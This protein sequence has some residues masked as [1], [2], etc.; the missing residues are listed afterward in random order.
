MTLNRRTILVSIAALLVIAVGATVWLSRRRAPTSR[1]IRAG[2][3]A[4]TA[5]SASSSIPGGPRPELV[6]QTGHLDR[7]A[8]VAF[9]P[10][11]RLLASS[12]DDGTVKLWDVESRRQLRSFGAPDTVPPDVG[13]STDGQWVTATGILFRAWSVSTGRSRDSDLQPRWKARSANGQWLAGEGDAGILVMKDAPGADTGQWLPRLLAGADLTPHFSPDDR[14]LAVEEMNRLGRKATVADM[15]D[16]AKIRALALNDSAEAAIQIWEVNTWR[17]VL[18]IPG[19][20]PELSAP[21][22]STDGRWLAVIGDG[23]RLVE[24]WDVAQAHQ[25]RTLTAPT[26]LSVVAFSPDSRFV[27]AAAVSKLDFLRILEEHGG[28]GREETSPPDD[29]LVLW[30]LSAE[31][32]PRTVAAGTGINALAFSPDGRKLAVAGSQGVTYWDPQEASGPPVRVDEGE[33]ESVTFSADGRRIA[34]AKNSS[35]KVR[36]LA[37]GAAAVVMSAPMMP[38]GFVTLSPDGR[39]LATANEER[40]S[41]KGADTGTVR[42]WDVAAGREAH[43]LFPDPTA[44]SAMLFSTD[45]RRIMTFGS[46]S[47]VWNTATGR[48]VGTPGD[49]PGQRPP[50]FVVSDDGRRLAYGIDEQFRIFVGDFESGKSPRRFSAGGPVDDLVLSADGRWLAT[51]GCHYTATR[52]PTG[53]AM[54]L[55][56][57]NTLKEIRT[58]N[59]NAFNLAISPDGRH[60]AAAGGAGRPGLQVWDVASGAQVLSVGTHV[61]GSV[62]VVNAISFSPDGRQVAFSDDQHAIQI[63]DVVARKQ[64]IALAGHTNYVG[65]IVFD[66]QGRIIS[67]SHDGTIRL[68]NAAAGELLVTLLF[69]QDPK[70]WLAVTP[71]GLFDGSPEAWNRIL[72]RFYENTFDVAPVDTFFSEFYYPGLLG[73]VFAGRR[74][75]P[76]RDIGQLDRRQPIVRL[77]AA[78]SDAGAI[79][80]RRI[81]VRVDVDEAHADA[82]H[83]AGSG[84]RDIRL[85]RDGSL[86]KAWRGDVLAS[87][88]GRVSLE[89]SVPIVAG[90]NRF[91]AYAFNHDNVKSEDAVL[92]VTGATGL[93]RQGTAYVLAV[94]VNEYANPTFNLKYAVADARRF[95]EVLARQQRLVGRFGDVQVIPLMDHDATKANV[96]AALK[97]LAGPEASPDGTAGLPASIP[98]IKPAE[99]EDLVVLFFAGHGVTDGARF[100]MVPHDLGYAGRRDA[101]DAEAV[102]TIARHSLSDQELERA[103]EDVDAGHLLLVIDACHSGQALEAAEKRQGPMNS[104]GLAQLAYEK[105][106]YVLTAAQS[107]QAAIE[108]ERLGHG[109]L[110]YALVETGLAAGGADYAPA[111]GSILLREWL[112]FSAERVPEL[113]LDELR[114]PR[115]M[116]LVFV[117][118]EESLTPEKRSLQRPRVFYRRELESQPLVV[119]RR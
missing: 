117:G 74:P 54:R 65:R 2:G 35:I 47:M 81:S 70:Q 42:L 84:A 13:F 10:D 111:D 28:Q 39:W 90:A 11:S 88:G 45:G 62:G 26:R 37:S 32:E 82:A 4:R 8:S 1:G 27:V 50:L 78:G 18:T 34:W 44:L 87:G 98:Q 7:V 56:D 108:L 53:C 76:P 92:S 86:V 67:T 95:G 17:K 109:L 96:L 93:A 118:G 48:E 91:T 23:R 9:S 61:F 36:E 58:W 102:K 113:Q 29:S 115:N 60:L 43:T 69:L 6:L 114:Q 100:Y 49:R 116:N 57:T 83:P 46:R 31:A 63:W 64:L 71:E 14:W 119:G 22:F 94:G 59:E 12:S 89:A 25:V 40:S 30:D 106:M 41:Q 24:V 19:R 80:A 103:L 55:W 38:V 77:S 107:Y 66:Q 73:E 75:A 79:E 3:A 104:K 101:L 112:D 21:V 110:T 85:F 15:A 16:Y 97:R 72:W 33:C 99:P 5:E 52:N 105:G 51:S 20:R 68:W